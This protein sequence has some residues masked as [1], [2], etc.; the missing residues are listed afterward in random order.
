M[1]GNARNISLG[2]VIHNRIAVAFLATH[3][4]FF[5]RRTRIAEHVSTFRT[6]QMLFSRPV[7]LFTTAVIVMSTGSYR[8]VLRRMA[9]HAGLSSGSFP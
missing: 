7:T 4:N 1:A 2:V 5:G 6:A 3:L 8:A 9:S